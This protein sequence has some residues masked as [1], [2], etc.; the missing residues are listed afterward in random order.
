MRKNGTID[1][2]DR[3]RFIGQVADEINAYTSIGYQTTVQ[4][5]AEYQRGIR[6]RRGRGVG[7]V[8]VN[9]NGL[10]LRILIGDQRQPG[11]VIAVG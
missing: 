9:L 11:I 6:L 5:A 3:E 1:R 10:A 8:L 7:V 2:R 4:H